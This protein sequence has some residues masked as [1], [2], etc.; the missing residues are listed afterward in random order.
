MSKNGIGYFQN[1][2]WI[3]ERIAPN[4]KSKKVSQIIVKN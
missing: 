2:I 4:E 1:K 3:I